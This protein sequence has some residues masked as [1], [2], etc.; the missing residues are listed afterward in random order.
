MY[1]IDAISS[2]NNSSHTKHFRKMA[3]HNFCLTIIFTLTFGFFTSK[4]AFAEKVYNEEGGIVM[5]EAENTQSALGLWDVKNNLNGYSGSGHIEFTGNDIRGGGSP[6]SMLKY[7]FKINSGG[8][9]KLIIRGQSRLFS[10]EA[11]D[12]A[13]DAWVRLD[14]DYE[15]GTGFTKTKAWLYHFQKMFVPRGGN[16]NWGFG[17]KLDNN[18]IQPAVI[19]NLKAGQTYTF[20][21]SGRSLRFNLDRII[22]VKTTS[23]ETTA[24]NKTTESNYFNDGK[25]IEVFSDNPKLPHGKLAVVADGNFRDSDD[26][27]GTPVGLAIL[28]A[29]GLSSNLVHYSHSCDLIS[30]SND[31]GGEYRQAEMQISCNGTVDRWGTFPNVTKFY[32]CMTEKSATINDLKNKIN[33]ASASDHLFIIE[34]G[35]PDIIYEA[36]KVSNVTSRQFVHI[37]THHPA[38]DI[39][40]TYDLIDLLNFG[41]KWNH[42][43]R[44]VDQNKLLKKPLS[45][46]NWAKNSSDPKIKWL[47]DR[48]FKAQTSEMNYPA[49]VG[50]MDCSD[51]GMTYYWATINNGGDEFC[52]VA[53]LQNL[54]TSNFNNPP[55][56][57]AILN[58]VTGIVPLAV[59]FNASASS[60]LDNDP[61]TFSWNFGDGTTGT[62]KNVNHTY[63][64]VGNYTAV[65]TVTD[66]KGGMDQTSFIV[67]VTEGQNT[68]PILS[69]VKP[70]ANERFDIGSNVIVEVLATDDGSIANVQLYLGNTLIRQEYIA[71]YEWGLSDQN[72]DLLT[73]MS[74]GSYTLKAIATDNTGKTS[75]T[76][77][78]FMVANATNHGP[79]VTFVKPLNSENMIEGTDM[80]I[81]VNAV[82]TDGTANVKLYLNNVFVRQEN[83]A[84]YEWGLSDQNDV[85]LTDMSPGNYTLLAVATDNAGMVG[86]KSISFTIS[87]KNVF[88]HMQKVNSTGFAIDGGTGASANQSVKLWTD[89]NSNINQQWNEIDRGS[90]YYSYQKVNSD[91]CIDG[92]NGG[93]NGQLLTLQLCSSSDQNQQWFKISA[94]S[95]KYRLQKR[96][97]SGYSIDGG[98][99]GANDVQL[100]LWT[101]SSSNQNQQWVFSTV[102]ELKSA[103]LTKELDKNESSSDLLVY[104]NPSRDGLFYLSTV[105]YW[106][107]YST[108]GLPIL[109]GNEAI[110]DLSSYAKGMYIL[111]TKD[112]T[113]KLIYK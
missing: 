75:E 56:A 42:L 39:G 62:G 54:L 38:N 15:I 19:Y 4:S 85:T 13:N 81:E 112:K 70:V 101:N 20:M 95:G 14:G 113:K 51:A 9:Y 82:D 53:K 52:D 90:G 63:N 8:D 40:D 27:A 18:H 106:T 23:N 11:N 47:Y 36:L 107:I 87:P 98:N 48:G 5:M 24:K 60:D 26:I 45:D 44:I 59:V 100:K 72:D 16:G 103:L 104:P 78:Q 71:P 99:G 34:A 6:K 105:E 86:E 109:K 17:I 76:L 30:G 55:V 88:V 73:N 41:I 84:P 97:A 77:L 68:N 74:A 29:F 93:A 57:S 58:P 37:I 49:I 94:G 91:Y 50:K 108:F 3:F 65:L 7:K 92:G 10:G 21:I 83:I 96:N 67:T 102:P 2:K 89:D 110:V 22:L 31:P 28:Q 66:G 35:E 61:L 1:N 79:V 12:L 46:W 111:K 25:P 43:H 69:F 64:A 32:N 80:L 33:N